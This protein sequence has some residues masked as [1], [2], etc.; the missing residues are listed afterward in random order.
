MAMVRLTVKQLMQRLERMPA[1]LPVIVHGYE[2]GYDP[3]TEFGLIAM[4]RNRNV[5][6]GTASFKSRINREKSRC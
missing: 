2:N 1:D 4:P 6:G 5:N 3:V